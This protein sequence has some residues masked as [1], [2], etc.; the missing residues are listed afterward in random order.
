MN[1][2]QLRELT[3]KLDIL[4]WLPEVGIG[5]YP[6]KEQPY[7]ADYWAKYR[8]MDQFPSGEYLTDFRIEFTQVNDVSSMVD[9]GIG[10]GRFCEDMDCA[11][12]DI[13]PKAIEWLKKERRWHNLLMS[14]KPVDH[15][16]FWDSLEHIH[17]PE[18]ILSRVKDSVFVSMPIYENAEHILKSKHFR[19]DE[20]CWYFTDDGLKWFM[21][22]FGFE[23]ERQSMG[24]QLYREDIHTYH[25]RRVNG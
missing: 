6:V 21:R 19:K 5:Y 2:D 15:L 17:D 23:C 25:F 16:T 8:E 14:E 1:L 24:E 18:T 10:G 3:T 9:V 11:G 13:N 22:L 7:D 20:H 4:V 12:F